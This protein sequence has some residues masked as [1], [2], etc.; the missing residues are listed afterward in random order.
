MVN[1]EVLRQSCLSQKGALE[2]FPFGPEVAVYKV[3]GKM[4]ALIPVAADPPSI[5]LKCDPTWAEVLRQTYPAVTPGYH[6]SK[7]HWNTIVVDGSI[8]ADEIAEMIVHSYG[9]V[10]KS[11][12]KRDRLILT[13]L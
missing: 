4:F 6:L 12:P 7:K 2:D 11:L 3:G 13:T 5:S 9:M 10:V 1:R 8:P